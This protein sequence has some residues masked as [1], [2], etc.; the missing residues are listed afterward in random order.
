M[1]KDPEI[2]Q[3]YTRHLGRLGA[4]HRG[5]D[6]AQGRQVSAFRELTDKWW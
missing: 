5:D 2:I 1:D 3:A 4:V 6:A